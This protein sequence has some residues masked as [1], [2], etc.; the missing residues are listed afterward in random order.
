MDI[1]YTKRPLMELSGI[2]L[3]CSDAEEA[4]A[5]ALSCGARLADRQFYDTSTTLLDPAGHPFCLDTGATE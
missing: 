4:V 1:D 3:D 2:V 5:F